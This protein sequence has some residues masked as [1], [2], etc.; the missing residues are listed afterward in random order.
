MRIGV[1]ER[2]QRTEQP[3]GEDRSFRAVGHGAGL[4]TLFDGFLCE[5]KDRVLGR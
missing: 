1:V 2:P 4:I 5:Q 3:R